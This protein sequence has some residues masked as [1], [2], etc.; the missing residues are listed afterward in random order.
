MNENTAIEE[1]DLRVEICKV[2]DITPMEGYDK[3]ELAWLYNKAPRGEPCI[4]QKGKYN[5]NDQVVYIPPDHVVPDVQEF[6]F[7][8]RSPDKLAPDEEYV[9]HKYRRIRPM[10][11]REY[12]SHGLVLDLKKADQI[13]MRLTGLGVPRGLGELVGKQL[14]ITRFVPRRRDGS[15]KGTSMGT[16]SGPKGMQVPKYEITGIRKVGDIFG[17][18]DQES[19]EILVVTEKLHGCNARFVVTSST[20]PRL[21]V[22]WDKFWDWVKRRPRK[23]VLFDDGKHKL[24][25]SSR[26]VWRS[27]KS[28]HTSF[29]KE[30]AEN[31]N[32]F[33]KLR[34]HPEFVFYGEIVG[35]RIQGSNFLYGLKNDEIGLYI[36]DVYIPEAKEWLAWDE[37]KAMCL[38]LGLETVPVIKFGNLKRSD[39]EP[40][41]EGKSIIDNHTMKEG[42]VVRTNADS[43]T[44]SGGR[45]IIKW[46]S[47]KFLQKHG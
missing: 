33:A 31:Q 29:W 20:K 22:L 1:A 41:V 24:H 43:R 46:K 2:K 9:R 47:E 5:V 12:I 38:R 34:K 3:L 25:I 8:E 14:G 42:V 27:T 17:W 19:A 40:V 13:A 30:I 10:K 37:L 45:K 6:A 36:F 28:E 15:L 21:R 4:V 35:R 16:E 18:E 32:L 7:L 44:P 11:L 23:F 26:T 39:V